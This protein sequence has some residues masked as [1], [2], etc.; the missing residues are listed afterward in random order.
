MSVANLKGR[1]VHIS[2]SNSLSNDIAAQDEIAFAREF[3]RDLVIELIRQGCSF[4]VPID[5]EPLRPDGATICYDWLVLET[6]AQNIA[7]RPSGAADPLIVA[8]QH[9]KSEDQ[10]PEQ[11][12]AL[13]DGLKGSAVVSIEN[14]SHWNMASKRMELQAVR[15]D[16]LITLGGCE[17][18]LF[19]ANLYSQSGKPV[20]P[21]NF[22]L[23]PEGKGSRRLFS[24]AME[25]A[26]SDE[27]FRP[28][29]QTAH[30]WINLLNFGTRHGTEHRVR[31][32]VELLTALQRPAAFA[33]RLLNPT[34]PNF[35]EVEDFFEVVVK[36]VIEDILGYRL[37]TINSGHTNE[38]PRVDEEI[39]AHLHQSSIVIADITAGRPNCFIELGYA[40]GRALPT[41]M[42]GREGSE[43]PFDT[44]SISGHFWNPALPAADRRSQFLQH[45]Q[46][47][48]NRPALVRPTVLIQ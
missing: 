44:N 2:G 45:I 43:N 7:L 1:T 47:N 34:H 22:K 15:G 20:I 38:Y 9:H 29:E 33:V 5:A 16:I 8:V 3:V 35:P 18:V 37:V 42:T 11:F 41:I 13:W 39:F 27:F 25:R 26:S 24:R 28:T 30:H 46:A 14:A 31:Q 36:Y 32:V 10:I 12:A 4:I 40:L 19:L 23:S 48:I 21:L 17:G 6:V